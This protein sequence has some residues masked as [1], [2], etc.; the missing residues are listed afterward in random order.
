M[1]SGNGWIGKAKRFWG[2]LGVTGVFVKWYWLFA[3]G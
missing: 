1:G 3:D 2:V